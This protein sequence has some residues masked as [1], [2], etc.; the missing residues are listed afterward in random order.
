MCYLLCFILIEWLESFLTVSFE[1]L[2]VI[3]KIVPICC[4]LLCGFID[5]RKSLCVVPLSNFVLNLREL[6]IFLIDFN[7]IL[8]I[9]IVALN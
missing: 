8:F 7:M 5:L 9:L 6:A 2:L 1:S 4:L 3:L